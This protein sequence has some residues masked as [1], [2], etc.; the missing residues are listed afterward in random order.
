[1]RAQLCVTVS[2]RTMAELRKRR[3]EVTDA[4]LIELRVD[5]AE[6]PSASAALAGRATPVVFTCRAAWE[7]GGFRGS[8][9]ERHRLLAEAQRL[10]ADYVDVE[11]RA[12]FDDVVSSR[13]GRGVVLSMH[14]FAGVPPDLGDRVRSMRS[15]NAAVVKVAV[16]AHRLS[17]CLPLREIAHPPGN[18][19]VVIAMGDA[20]IATRVLASRFGSAWTF[21]GDGVAPGQ[22]PVERLRRELAFD[23]VSAA[24][25]VYGVVGRPILHSLSPAMHNAAFRAAGI[26]AVFVPFA[27]ADFADF[28]TFAEALDVAGSSVTAP[29][30]LDA[31][32]HATARDAISARIGSA[33]TL[34]RSDGEWSVRNTDVAGFLEPLEARLP[35]A[36]RRA[37][38]LGAGG[39]ARAVVEALTS[40]GARVT[41]AARNRRRAVDLATP[42][43]ASVGEW[44]PAAGS[45]DVLV[46]A[47]PLGTTPDV[48]ETPLPGGPF[49]GELVYDLV[50]N[51]RQTRF[52]R[53]AR[54]AGCRTIEGLDMLIAQAERQFEWWTGHRPVEGVMRQAAILALERRELPGT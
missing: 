31:F 47:T 36:G 48:D 13:H 3:D 26:D 1:M 17:D 25:A 51:P 49:G 44:P 27:A 28:V 5:L 29:F 24:S 37:T 22:L 39:A 52:L 4:D 21:A 10:G 19:T 23:R 12:G 9:E 42:V 43:G 33:N 35:L 54:A 41:I 32:A 16:M 20:G 53:E 6:D 34:K 14:D 46:N 38:V 7:G 18:G 30:K 45:W 8:E 50:Y 40:A 15:T 11:W 2:G